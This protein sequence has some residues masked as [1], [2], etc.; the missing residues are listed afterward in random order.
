MT[1]GIDKQ[2]I[3]QQG[4]DEDPRKQRSRSRLLDAATTLL[5]EGGVDAVTIDAVTKLANVARA[6]LYRH[7]DSGTEL[8]AAA[9]A[10]LLPPVPEMSG[11]GDLR[12][13]L[14]ELLTSQDK[15]IESAP[16]Q[17]TAMCWLG[18]GPELKGYSSVD[19]LSADKPELRSLR[20]TVFEQYRHAFDR[21]LRSPDAID[22]LGE[23]DYDVAL[24]QLV[25]PLVLTKLA[26]LTPLGEAA[27]EQIV[28]DFLAA[29]GVSS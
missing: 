24:A 3:E 14:L 5:A 25:G 8:L 2:G 28:D 1:V 13:Q 6:T 23:Y 7:F 27:C 11:E 10:R 21:I 12:A 18:L 22:A 19:A 29:R 26:T 17:V 9:F 20:Q 16:I 15:A 4:N